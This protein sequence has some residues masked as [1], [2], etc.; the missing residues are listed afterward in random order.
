MFKNGSTQES[1]FQAYGQDYWYP[2][3]TMVIG[4]K[5]TSDTG[6]ANTDGYNEGQGY[7]STSAAN[8]TVEVEFSDTRGAATAYTYYNPVIKI[9]NW[10]WPN[11][12]VV[13]K[14]TDDGATWTFLRSDTD[15]NMTTEADEAQVGTNIRY[16]QYL[17]T[18]TG[19]GSSTTHFRISWQPD[20]ASIMRHGKAYNNGIYIPFT[21]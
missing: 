21:F 18:V 5:V 15:Y 16:F 9:S 7:Y 13:E 11:T 12:V 4:S 3:Y 2:Y 19:S 6:D 8:N 1:T 17:G 20:M 14:S 10:T